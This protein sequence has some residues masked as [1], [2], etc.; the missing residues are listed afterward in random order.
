MKN[1]EQIEMA[2]PK[3]EAKHGLELA[4]ISYI[5]GGQRQRE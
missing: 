3:E 4:L 1:Q 2:D 5:L